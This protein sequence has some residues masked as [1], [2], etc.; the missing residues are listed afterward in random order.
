VGA[1]RDGVGEGGIDLDEGEPILDE[2]GEGESVV[3]LFDERDRS[4]EVVEVVVVEASDG[5]E[6]PDNLLGIDLDGALRKCGADEHGSASDAERAEHGFHGFWNATAIDRYRDRFGI[7]LGGELC[8]QIRFARAEEQGVIDAK[9]E[10]CG[11]AVSGDVR[12]EDPAGAGGTAHGSGHQPQHAGTGDQ[13]RAVGHRSGQTERSG[14][15]GERAVDEREDGEGNGGIDPCDRRVPA[16]EA[17][18]GEASMEMTGCR[19]LFMAVFEKVR[20]LL[21]DTGPGHARAGVGGI[22][23]PGDAVAHPEGGSTAVGAGSIG[24]EGCD[25][26]NDLVA[27]D[28]GCLLGA[29]AQVGVEVASAERRVLVPDEDLAWAGSGNSDRFQAEGRSGRIEQCGKARVHVRRYPMNVRRK[30]AGAGGRS[31]EWSRVR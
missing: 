6:A 14:N 10:G 25:P 27:E 24:T 22:D 2:V 29:F 21:R 1:G 8:L 28:G 23:G 11:E 17:V 19:D 26:T 12:G 5:E 15:R 16:E 7:G 30:P 4:D 20:C 13:D 18:F 3:V 9:A 31:V